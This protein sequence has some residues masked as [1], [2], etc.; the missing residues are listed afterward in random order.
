MRASM[1]ELTGGTCGI[2]LALAK[3]SSDT[4]VRCAVASFE[5][6]DGL[7]KARQLL[8]D[9]DAVL[10]QGGGL[11]DLRTKS[12]DLTVSRRAEEAEARQRRSPLKCAALRSPS[13][14]L[15]AGNLMAQTGGAGAVG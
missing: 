15:N 14:R 10:I 1:A 6:T 2:G 11:I 8:V 5:G 7:F 13:F 9:T 3:D 4:E 12:V